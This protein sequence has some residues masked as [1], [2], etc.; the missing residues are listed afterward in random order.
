MALLIWSATNA[1]SCSASGGWAGDQ[2]SSGSVSTGALSG[3][4]SYTLSC[5][6]P[7][8]RASRSV[9]V[10]VSKVALNGPSC[11]ASSGGLTLRASAARK[12]GESPLLMFFDAT[13]TTSS[14]VANNSSAFQDIAYRW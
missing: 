1:S 3:T 5:T 2:P 13:G 14:S 12:S 10:S 6:G 8:G 11:S 4:T 7:G 9:Q